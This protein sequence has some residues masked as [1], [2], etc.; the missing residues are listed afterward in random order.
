MVGIKI[1]VIVACVAPS[2]EA[3]VETMAVCIP[4]ITMVIIMTVVAVVTEVARMTGAAPSMITMVVPA[5]VAVRIMPAP[6]VIES[7]VIVTM[8]VIVRT[9]VVGRPVPVVT[10]IHTHAPVA[11]IIIIPI[12]IGVVRIVVAP[13]TIYTSMETTDTRCIIVIIV[14]VV[15]IIIVIGNIGIT[16]FA[17]VIAFRSGVIGRGGSFFRILLRDI[18]FGIIIVFRRNNL[19]GVHGR[20]GRI[21]GIR[22]SA[23]DIII[24]RQ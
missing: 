12:H 3:V 6:A 11:G 22:G 23:I 24:I 13:T 20:S 18:F 5:V 1:V 15:I 21:L 9:I 19:R 7:A 4:A 8:R 17:I 2:D 14:I 10:E 16:R